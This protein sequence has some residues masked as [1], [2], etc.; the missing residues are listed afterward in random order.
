MAAV[1]VGG[2][3]HVG[4]G[5]PLALL[6]GPCAIES[7]EFTVE[8]GHAIRDVCA[9]LDMPYVFKA[10]YDKA[11]RSSLDSFRGPGLTAGL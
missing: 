2:A 1:T 10:S 9:R 8:M 3:V 5:N 7:E 6:G 4:G 11:N